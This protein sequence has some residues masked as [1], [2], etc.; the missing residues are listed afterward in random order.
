MVPLQFD[1]ARIE[2]LLATAS[3]Q[4]DG[5]WLEIGGAWVARGVAAQPAGVISSWDDP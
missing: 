2:A 1:K 4:L 5:E 3:E